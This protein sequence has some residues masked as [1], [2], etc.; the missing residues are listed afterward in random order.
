[1]IV[2][3]FCPP[4]EEIAHHLVGSLHTV[5]ER[6]LPSTR[7]M[8]KEVLPTAI[9][10]KRKIIGRRFLLLIRLKAFP[11]TRILLCE[12]DFTQTFYGLCLVALPIG[13]QTTAVVHLN[14]QLIGQTKLVALDLDHSESNRTFLQ[15]LP[16]W[17]CICFTQ[18]CSDGNEHFDHRIDRRVFLP[19]G[20]KPRGFHESGLRLV[21]FQLLLQFSVANVRHQSGTEAARGRTRGVTEMRK[22]LFRC[23][24]FCFGTQHPVQQPQTGESLLSV[25]R[26]KYLCRFVDIRIWDVK[27]KFSLFPMWMQ[28]G[29]RGFFVRAAVNEIE[30]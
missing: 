24:G 18:P 9:D 16:K 29:S 20:K 7:E 6:A 22:Q 15:T 12:N 10:S 5:F 21:G 11:Q 8:P 27:M 3:E 4:S 17:G 1:M 2:S 28:S 30:M 13:E 25:E 14:I 26:K 23:V 19:S